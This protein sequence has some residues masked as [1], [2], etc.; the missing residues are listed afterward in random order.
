LKVY[1]TAA[2]GSVIANTCELAQ[3]LKSRIESSPELE[4]MAPVA[5]NIV[6]FRYRFEPAAAWFNDGSLDQLSDQ[7]DQELVIRLQESGIA[8]PSQT[9]LHGRV[10][11]RAAIVNH[12]TSRSEIDSLIAATLSLGRELTPEIPHA[13]LS[14]P[15]SA[16]SC[17]YR[18]STR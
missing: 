8:A 17:A 13:N 16:L 3:Y 14:N 7:L 4:L 15:A 11:I 1:G 9:I 10:V 5:L 12:R 6:C 2:I 18:L